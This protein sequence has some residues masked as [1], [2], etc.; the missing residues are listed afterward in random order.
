MTV[1]AGLGIGGSPGVVAHSAARATRPGE[2]A[3]EK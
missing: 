1:A 2:S 3:T